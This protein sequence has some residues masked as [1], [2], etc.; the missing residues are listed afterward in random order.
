M[1]HFKTY[2][3]GAQKNHLIIQMVFH[4]IHNVCFGWEIWKFDFNYTLVTSMGL[5]KQ[6]FSV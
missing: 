2:V 6:H 1:R 5:D 3:L 4:S